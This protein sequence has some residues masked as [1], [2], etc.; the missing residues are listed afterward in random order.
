[1]AFS[2]TVHL[3]RGDFNLAIEELR[4]SVESDPIRWNN[5]AVALAF[6]SEE[7]SS[8]VDS[9]D[10]AMRVFRSAI[11]IAKPKNETLANLIERNMGIYEKRDMSSQY[12]IELP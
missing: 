3:F 1:V 12:Y 9:N 6:Q 8:P 5:L 2:G 10:G 7:A 11:D 4:E